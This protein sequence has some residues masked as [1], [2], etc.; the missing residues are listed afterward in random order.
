MERNG[1]NEKSEETADALP[2][3]PASSVTCSCGKK[4]EEPAEDLTP[5][6]ED[7]GLD[8][9]NDDSE[10][11]WDLDWGDTDSDEE[12]ANH[13]TPGISTGMIRAA[14]TKTKRMMIGASR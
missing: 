14:K 10:D 5:E 11:S 12:I 7:W 13:R 2:G 1:H 3:R 4:E 8:E 6:T 9:E